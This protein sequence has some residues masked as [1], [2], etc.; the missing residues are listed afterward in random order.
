MDLLT[1]KIGS[2]LELWLSLEQRERRQKRVSKFH[3]VWDGYDNGA[4]N[5]HIMLVVFAFLST[6]GRSWKKL[7]A[8]VAFSISISSSSGKQ[9]A[10]FWM[11]CKSNHIECS[12]L[13]GVQCFNGYRVYFTSGISISLS[14]SSFVG[15]MYMMVILLHYACIYSW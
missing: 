3:P 6:F 7:E 11:S 15:I 4:K 13:L 2:K 9:T 5:I 12:T 8:F 10:S 1:V 14:Q